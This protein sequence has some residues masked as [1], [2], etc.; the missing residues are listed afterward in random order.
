VEYDL[1]M[2]RAVFFDIDGTLM[3]TNYLHVEAWA[4]AF[5]QVGVIV[6]RREIH[7]H[8]GKSGKKM[9]SGPARWPSTATAPRRSKKAFRNR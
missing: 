4:D 9:V 6:P 3:D 5:E 7:R 8:I 2:I 1:T